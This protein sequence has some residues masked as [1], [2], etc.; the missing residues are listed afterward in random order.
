[1]EVLYVP[2]LWKHRCKK[3]KSIELRNCGH[4]MITHDLVAET[5]AAHNTGGV[6]V[7]DTDKT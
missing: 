5:L 3:R 6:G 1:M 7:G 4:T 2:L